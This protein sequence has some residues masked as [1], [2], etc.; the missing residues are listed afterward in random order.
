MSGPVADTGLPR[1]PPIQYNA[2]LGTRWQKEKAAAGQGAFDFPED[3]KSIGPWIIGECVGKGA[4]GRVKIARHARTGQLA[5]IKI[6]PL[7]PVVSA[8][9]TSVAAHQAKSEKQRLGIDREITMMKLMNHP[10]I[11]RIY[12]VYE[13]DKELFLILEYVEGGELFDFLV[14]RGKLPHLQALAYFKQIVYGLNYAHTFSIIHRDLK[15]ENILIHSLNPPLIKIADWGMAAFAPPDRQLDTSCGSPHYASPEIVNGLKYQGTATD[16]WSC[17]VI[18][19]ALLTGRLPFDD[20]NVKNLL[21]KV[22]T[23]KY[24]LP[25]YIDSQARDLLSRM[26][27]V[28]VGKRI[29]MS[30]VLGHPWLHNDTPGITCVLA[31]S[32]SELAQPLASAACIDKDLLESLRVI[33]GRSANLEIIKG[34]LLSPPGLGTLAKAFYFLLQKHRERNLEERG[35]LNVQRVENGA[36][37]TVTL[38]QYTSPKPSRMATAPAAP[39]AYI[40]T[41]IPHSYLS[42]TSLTATSPTPSLNHRSRPVSPAGPRPRPVSSSGPSP[43][44]TSPIYLGPPSPG[45]VSP[46][47][48]S[49][50]TPRPTAVRISRLPSHQEPTPR[51]SPRLP[52]APTI[53]APVPQHARAS[54]GLLPM[55]SAPRMTTSEQQ[56]TMDDIAN[57]MNVLVARDNAA[58]VREQDPR[59]QAHGHGQDQA[60]GNR[61]VHLTSRPLPPVRYRHNGGAQDNGEWAAN[62]ENNGNVGGRA[63]YGTG[64]MMASEGLGFGKVGVRND[65]GHDEGQVSFMGDHPGLKE[66]EAQRRERRARLPPLDFH[67]PTPTRRSTFSASGIKSPTLMS[68]ASGSILGSPVMGEFKGWFSSLFN[69]KQSHVLYSTENLMSTREEVGRLLM[70][71]G[72]VICLEDPDVMMGDASGLGMLKCRVDDG[73]EVGGSAK[74]ARFRVEF[75]ASSELGRGARGFCCAVAMIQEKGSV[76]TFKTVYRRVREEWRLDGGGVDGGFG[77]PSPYVG[78]GEVVG[79]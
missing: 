3:P 79:W 43:R 21:A 73:M 65:E 14:N 52:P 12:D 51:P 48:S 78:A 1:A 64:P 2:P 10:N 41:H 33:W 54:L 67:G 38:R 6:L 29:T 53:L 5:A 18:L 34:D 27:V 11:M 66:A 31:P 61:P 71:A 24:D 30:E 49:D 9:T 20:K 40:H 36:G 17:G 28:D 22:K 39:Q 74:G 60:Y 57:R 59:H 55:V 50:T 19:Y 63:A 25:S 23:G 77:Y 35:I 45:S 46:A 42:P 44:Q 32:V 26:L 75:S 56:R 13:G 62:K 69:W 4:S 72:V 76:S 70:E 8:R 15:P 68:P 47:F 7:Q 58:D 37:R 16:I